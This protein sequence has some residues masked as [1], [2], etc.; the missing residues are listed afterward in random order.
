VWSGLY[1]VLDNAS[2]NPEHSLLATQGYAKSFFEEDDVNE[3]VKYSKMIL[4]KILAD[5]NKLLAKL[6]T[7]QEVSFYIIDIYFNNGKY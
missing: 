2:S 6:D 3:T 5:P 7:Y 1:Y 4:A